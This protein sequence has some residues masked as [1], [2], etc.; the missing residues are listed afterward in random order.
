MSVANNKKV[1]NIDIA[2]AF[3]T[4]QRDKYETISKSLEAI[5]ENLDEDAGA[6]CYTIAN[7][8][9]LK[10]KVLHAF[11]SGYILGYE[12]GKYRTEKL[13]AQHRDNLKGDK[14]E[15]HQD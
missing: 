2:E 13:N 8:L 14:N 10:E 4:E 15:Q 9:E 3:A 6:L 5:I 7:T 1:P 11:N 12:Y